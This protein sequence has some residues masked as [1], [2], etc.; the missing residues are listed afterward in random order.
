VNQALIQSE[1]SVSDIDPDAMNEYLDTAEDSIIDFSEGNP[2]GDQ[3][4][5]S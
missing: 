1:Y 4:A 5:T 3:G 2:F